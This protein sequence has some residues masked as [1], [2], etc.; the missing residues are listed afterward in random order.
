VIKNSGNLGCYFYPLSE[1]S[2]RRDRTDYGQVFDD[3]DGEFVDVAAGNRASCGLRANGE[4]ECWGRLNCPEDLFRSKTPAVSNRRDKPSTGKRC[5]LSEK[6]TKIVGTKQRFC[7]LSDSGTLGCWGDK[8][9]LRDS[10]EHWKNFDSKGG[11]V[12]A[13]SKG[14]D[15]KCWGYLEGMGKSFSKNAS[16]HRD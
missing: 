6:P 3:V 10:S 15:V 14:G 5:P 16:V 9:Q 11:S 13:I 4:L 7:A 12:C 2:A 8:L 1:E